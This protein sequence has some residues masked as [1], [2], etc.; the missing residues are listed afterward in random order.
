[1]ILVGRKLLMG[2]LAKETLYEVDT[3]TGEGRDLVL[4]EPVRWADSFARGADGSVYF[5]TSEINYDKM[6]RVPYGL[7]RLTSD[8]R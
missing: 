8:G 4:P 6:E 1:M 7:Y 2:D 5:T 3:R